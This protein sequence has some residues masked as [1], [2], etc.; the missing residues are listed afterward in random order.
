[1]V[2]NNLFN[3]KKMEEFI[4]LYDSNLVIN[5]PNEDP[6]CDW[7]KKL[8][9]NEL[10]D[11]KKNYANFLVIIL[12]RLLG[13]KIEDIAYE[14]D[15]GSEGRPVEFTFKK[16]EKE[17]VVVELK[18]TKTKDLN[19]RYNRSQSAIEQVT[20]YASI[21]EETQWAELQRKIHLFQIQIFNR[22]RS[23]KEILT[24]FFKILFN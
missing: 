24:Y 5:S 10:E 22:P 17:Y 19:K 16:G 6:V 8:N 2:Y 20:N 15:P 12:E 13:Y 3:E 11:E 4:E 14:T 23:L 9:N 21:K 7:I 1:M 18:G